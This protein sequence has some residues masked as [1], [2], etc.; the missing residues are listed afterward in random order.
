M[1]SI[2]TTAPATAEAAPKYGAPFFEHLWRGAGTQAV[3]FAVVG[4]VV[5]AFQPF[6]AAP[7]LG[8]AILNLT[9]WVAELR[10][11]LADQGLDGWG[12]AGTAASAAFAGIAFAMVAIATV[13]PSLAGS[14]SDA[15][16]TGL[17]SLGSAAWVLSSF[18][19]AMMVMAG[20][21][22]FWRAGFI[23]TNQFKVAVGLVILGV[24]GGTTW[25]ADGVWGQN[26]LLSWI[27]LPALEL[28][29]VVAASRVLNRAPS[30]RTGF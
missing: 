28:V 30:T 21:F 1:T 2:S 27:I 29:W 17:T 26:G 3:A 10:T 6:I 4:L 9:W 22:G 8:L 20:S 23:T 24:L 13:V 7:I 15:I 18:P 19:R 11:T 25:F 12:A 16:V 5:Y 14:G